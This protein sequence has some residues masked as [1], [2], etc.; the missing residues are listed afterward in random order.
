MVSAT[1][2]IYAMRTSIVGSI[3][4]IGINPDVKGLLN[5][6]GIKIEMMKVGQYKVMLTPFAPTSEEAK[7]KYMKILENSYAVLKNSVSDNRKLT[8]ENL[9][10]STNG[11]ICTAI[12]AQEIDLIDKFSPFDEALEDIVKTYQLK[13]K[14]RLLEP[15]RFLFERMFMSNSFLELIYKLFNM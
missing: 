9:E 15:H 10:L 5:K 7:E 2:K 4:V 8:A 3:G 12:R 1:N 13:P 11:E 14:L 6:L